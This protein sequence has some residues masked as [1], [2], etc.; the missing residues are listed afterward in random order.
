MP[1][2]SMK[3]Y[4]LIIGTLNLAVLSVRAILSYFLVT[5]TPFGISQDNER[6]FFSQNAEKL[7][8]FGSGFQD[9]ISGN[10]IFRNEFY[11]SAAVASPLFLSSVIFLVLL[12][13][14]TKYRDHLTNDSPRFL[15]RWSIVFICVTAF[16][17]PVFAQDFWLS[18]GWGRMA[19]AGTNPYYYDL[20]LEFTRTLPLD[21]TGGRM[22]YGPL[23]VLIS[24]IL[25]WVAGGNLL[26]EAVLFKMLLTGAL[27][28]SLFLVWKL[29]ADRPLFHQCLGIAMFGWLPL[30]LTEIAAEGHNDIMMVFFLLLWLYFLQRGRIMA[31]GIALAASVLTKYVTAPLF[32][33]EILYFHFSLKRSPR[34]YMLP[35]LAAGAFMVLVTGVFFRSPDF[36]DATSSMRAWHFFTP[37]D[38]IAA[39]CRLLGI[40][41]HLQY[42]PLLIFPL[43]AVYRVFRYVKV[44]TDDTFR[45][46]ILTVMSAILFTAPGHIFPWYLLWVVPFS[47][48]L[49][50]QPLSRWNIGAALAF[51]F[52]LLPLQFTNLSGFWR[53]ELPGLLIYVFALIWQ[54]SASRWLSLDTTVIEKNTEPLADPA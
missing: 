35:L 41:G 21:F 1:R 54:L 9:L 26:A 51:P 48:L 24:G 10:G 52:A 23:W 8:L 4:L 25:A 16:S 34:T 47:V 18:I 30:T 29:L 15:F 36:F 40:P 50:D 3:K 7:A 43:L 37:R 14:L 42:L 13:L 32:L 46:M 44:P 6:L 49:P 28:G 45:L 53:W 12:I 2:G 5:V 20:T 39:L 17:F 22:T 27:I 38:A 11:F 33:V 31:T 19:A